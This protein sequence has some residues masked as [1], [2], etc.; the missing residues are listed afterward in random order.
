MDK[1]ANKS[2]AKGRTIW[3]IGLFVLSAAL[4]V[5]I[6][7]IGSRAA[8]GPHVTKEGTSYVGHV[9]TASSLQDAVEKWQYVIRANS[10]CNADAF[11]ETQGYNGNLTSI[12][13]GSNIY[14]ANAQNEIDRFD[15]SYICFQASDADD[16]NATWLGVQMR[17]SD[18]DGGYKDGWPE[19]RIGIPAAWDSFT[20]EEKIAANPYNCPEPVQIDTDGRCMLGNGSVGAE[21]ECPQD[22]VRVTDENGDRCEERTGSEPSDAEEPQPRLEISNGKRHLY[23]LCCKCDRPAMEIHRLGRIDLHRSEF[24]QSRS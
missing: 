4:I 10:E 2:T 21:G 8:G 14:S 3:I 17:F 22:Q 24:P 16:S 1:V 19:V 9:S 20:A 15:G 23:R 11:A 18:S 6:L 7:G 13:K 12:V 5:A